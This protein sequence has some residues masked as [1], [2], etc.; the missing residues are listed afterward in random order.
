[1]HTVSTVSDA[2]FVFSLTKLV[3]YVDEAALDSIAITNHNIF[4]L[5][6]YQKISDTLDIVVFPGIE[7]DVDACHI[8]VIA[9]PRNISEFVVATERV[10]KKITTADQY[11]SVDEFREI[12]VAPDNYIVIP[13]YQKKPEI[14]DSTLQSLDGWVNCGEVN[15]VKKFVR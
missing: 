15:S 12:F 11:I 6:Q 2:E 14:R 3:E 5:N 13:H 1:M 8:L 10:S 4:D 9:D 7:V